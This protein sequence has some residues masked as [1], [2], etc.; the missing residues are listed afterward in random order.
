M[1]QLIMTVAG[2]VIGGLLGGPIGASI[3]MT[4]GGAVGATLFGPT[5]K[6]P[7]LS[8]LK[9]TAS[10]YGNVIPKGYGT[11]RVG[12]NMIWSD[13]IEEVKK[14]Q[15]G[16]GGPKQEV[17]YYYST[18]AM[19][20]CEGEI[21]DIT[22]I[23]ADGKLILDK[24]GGSH[25]QIKFTGSL[26]TD[27]IQKIIDIQTAGLER[28]G[29]G[30][31]FGSSKYKFRLYKGTET[32]LPDSI[33]ES[34]LGVGNVS[35]HR[36][37]AYIV[38]DR[39]PLEDFGNRVPQLTFEVVK[40]RKT[41]LPYIISTDKVTGNGVK[42][43]SRFFVDYTNGRIFAGTSYGNDNPRLSVLDGGTMAEIQRLSLNLFPSQARNC[44]VQGAGLFVREIGSRNSRQ[45]IVQDLFSM[46]TIETIGVASNS[47]S[48]FFT[49]ATKANAIS[50]V[51]PVC[52]HI[53]IGAD[54]REVRLVFIGYFRDVWARTV[55]KEIPLFNAKAAFVPT[56]MFTARE[57]AAG[58]QSVGWRMRDGYL[59]RRGRDQ[60]RQMDSDET[61]AEFTTPNPSCLGRELFPLF[62]RV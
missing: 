51:G 34:K 2:G 22:R 43:M 59:L 46:S 62:H 52:P 4:L 9:V 13:G 33:M 8:D 5:I 7:R 48:G 10:T 40:H 24:T 49:P 6:G 11:F 58:G 30:K 20:I 35:A 38:F 19:S 1:G 47:T 44:Y 60:G 26:L 55:G 16:K 27:T 56:G 57:D 21:E 50:G 53:G 25:K 41:F 45:C 37:M 3:G 14:K 29:L 32:Q 36:G 42:D 15:G 61:L 39:M 17:Y 28:T 23:W 18:Y 54:G 12:G 31:V